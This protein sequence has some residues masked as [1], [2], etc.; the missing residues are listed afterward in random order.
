MVTVVETLASGVD[1]VG[2]GAGDSLGFDLTGVTSP[3][4]ALST[5]D[6]TLFTVTGSNADNPFGTFLD[7]IK[8]DDPGTC[9]GGSKTYAGPLDFTVSSA[10]GVDITD[11]KSTSSSYGNVYF[12]SDIIDNNLNG[13][14]TGVVGAF[15]GIVTTA[16]PEPSSLLLL[17]TGILGLAGVV[18]RRLMA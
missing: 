1:F 10:T 17:G 18:R 6:S 14:P 5:T 16:V 2:T 12:A 3:T 13:C 9:H 8:C 11:F 7:N 15:A 4:I